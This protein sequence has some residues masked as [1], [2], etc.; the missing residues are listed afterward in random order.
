[1]NPHVLPNE[2]AVLGTQSYSATLVLAG[3]TDLRAIGRAV[4]NVERAVT[5]G[6]PDAVPPAP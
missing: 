4:E 2:W 1:M 5:T 3:A 6:N